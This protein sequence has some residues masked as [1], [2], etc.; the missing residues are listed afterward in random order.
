MDQKFSQ[1][2][3]AL[4]TILNIIITKD[5]RLKELRKIEE[6]ADGLIYLTEKRRKLLF[7]TI[8]AF[9]YELKK[10][11]TNE[12]CIGGFYKILKEIL[13]INTSLKNPKCIIYGDNWLSEEVSNKMRDNNYCTFSW[14][15]VNPA[16]V[17]EYDLY[18]L[19]NEPLK[20]YNLATIKDE[21][22]IIK[23]WDYLK[24]KYI[25][26]PSFYEIYMKFKKKSERKVKCLV[27]GN[28]NI[29]SAVQADMLHTNAASLAN[30]AQ[31]IFY[32]FK[33]FQHA[34]ILTPDLEYAIIGLAPYSLRYDASK[35]KVEWRRCL[36]YYPLVGTMHN[37]DEASHLIT[38]Y[39]SENKK[40]EQ[41]FS[42]KDMDSLYD[43]FAELEKSEKKDNI[44]VYDEK[45]TSK[46]CAAL[47]VREIS[48]LYNRPSLE[49]FLENKILLDEY[50]KLCKSKNLK[51]IF[52][53]PPYTTWYKAHMQKSYYEELLEVIN[54]LGAKYDAQIIDMMNVSLPDCCFGDYANV[55]CIGAV[56]VA[57]Y[58]NEVIDG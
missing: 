37:C 56:K 36:A 25:V 43:I 18:I 35:S 5:I 39:E 58:L 41:Y 6:Y 48:E 21:D 49:V 26:F 50:A 1:L 20:V 34:Y 55:N 17:N 51:I 2:E 22:K 14:H 54:E 23:I 9:R 42:E 38:I 52:F 12:E 40:I 3:T 24:Y 11:S 57:S 4:N 19:C 16:Y 33:M 47:N 46:E 7:G 28:T 8:K 45:T 30:N 32:D 15:A 53:I 31:D 29:V 13:S 27:T 44:E 10:R